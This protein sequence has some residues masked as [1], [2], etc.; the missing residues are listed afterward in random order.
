MHV[1]FRKYRK[2]E[3]KEAVKNSTSL[4][5]VVNKLDLS[6]SGDCYR[7]IKNKIKTLDLDVSHFKNKINFDLIFGSRSSVRKFVIDNNLIKYNC[8]ECEIF[9]WNKKSLCLQLDHIDGNVHNNDLSNLRF[10][11]PNCHSQTSTWGV[12]NFDR[13]SIIIR[14]LDCKKKITR[15]S[16]RCQSCASKGQ[17][18]KIDWHPIDILKKVVQE[19]SDVAVGCGFSV[20]Y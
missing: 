1:K 5:Q 4:S 20:P 17:R 13:P 19:S 7:S 14:C 11:C 15:T 16:K 12:K 18:T 2:E 3:F 9:E 6:C 10:L 8:S